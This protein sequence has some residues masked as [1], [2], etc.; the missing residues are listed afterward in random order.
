M[1]TVPFPV[2]FTAVIEWFRMCPEVVQETAAEHAHDCSGKTDAPLGT[3][4]L[5]G[6][7]VGSTT[8]SQHKVLQTRTIIAAAP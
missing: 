6:H 1:A 8:V 3:V 2:T 5:G 7:R 4:A